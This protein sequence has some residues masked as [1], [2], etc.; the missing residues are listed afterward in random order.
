MK[1]S[2]VRKAILILNSAQLPAAPDSHISSID[3]RA[4]IAVTVVYL[5]AMLS[6]P[7]NAAGMLIWFAIYPIITSPL[8]HITYERVFLRSLYVLPLIIA[9]GIFNPIYDRTE[10]FEVCG[11]SVSE[12]WISFFSIVIRGLLSVQALLL[13]IHVAGFNR[14]CEGLRSLHVPTVL[15]TQILLAYRYMGVLLQ[16]AQ[17]MHRARQARGYGQ[18]SYPVSM[19]GPLVGQLLIRSIERSR[20]IF[21]AMQARGFDGTLTAEK[22]SKWDVAATLYCM[23]WFAVIITLRLS[24]LSTLL[25]NILHR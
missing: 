8:A 11:I 24:D 16:E 15:V 19:W 9:I 13:L 3:P 7:L 10:A 25:L 12:G 21:A 4:L 20:R 1:A 2:R 22:P 6:V 14:I 5:V 23:I 17:T 18:K